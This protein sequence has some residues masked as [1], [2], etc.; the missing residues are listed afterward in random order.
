MF[1]VSSLAVFADRVTSYCSLFC[2][3]CSLCWAFSGLTIGFAFTNAV[4]VLDAAI[5]AHVFSVFNIVAFIV[6][7]AAWIALTFSS[8][9]LLVEIAA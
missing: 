3:A 1:L 7:I 8:T 5:C 9:L 6:A 2:F 4:V